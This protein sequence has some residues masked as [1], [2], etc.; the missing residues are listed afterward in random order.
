MVDIF[1][2][3]ISAMLC[4]GIFIT[5]IQLI[6]PKTNLKKYIYSLIG[7]VTV[8]TV[9][10]PVINLLKNQTV[11]ESVTE[12]LQNIS[13]TDTAQAYDNSDFEKYKE[14]KENAV[15]TGFVDSLKGDVTSKLKEKGVTVQSVEVFLDGDYN[16]EKM[17]IKIGKLN[18][19]TATLSSVN[20]V[21]DYVH[22]EY[23]IDYSK[24]VVIEEGVS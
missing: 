5:F 3:W 24:I 2:N 4:I 10:S 22:K 15:K 23:D 6:I 14:V 13:S 19:T 16:I 7:I 1:K 11:E 17:E 21:V 18:G 20:G 8:L 12:V 9:V